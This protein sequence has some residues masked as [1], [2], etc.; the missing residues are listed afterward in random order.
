EVMVVDTASGIGSCALG[1][2][3]AA[4]EVVV[5][6]CDEPASITDA[7]ATI[8]VMSRERG[9]RHFRVLCNK[10]KDKAHGAALFAKLLA[11]C[12]RFLDV[13]LSHF[14]CVPECEALRRAARLQK[15]VVEGFPTSP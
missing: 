11:V 10:V 3:A 13:S 6:V 4:H 14:G 1:F 8:K 12:D 15:S 9:V 2:G 5:A 7:Y